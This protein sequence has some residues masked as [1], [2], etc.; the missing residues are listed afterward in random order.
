MLRAR[1]ALQLLWG[2]MFSGKPKTNLRQ[3]V[4]DGELG[5]CCSFAGIAA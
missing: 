4:V 2:G 1:L 5:S 3:A